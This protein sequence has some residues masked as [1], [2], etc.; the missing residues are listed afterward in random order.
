MFA[1]LFVLLY[2][3]HLLADYPLQTDHQAAHKGERTAVGWRANATHT[4][5]HVGTSAALLATG[6]V[7]LDLRYGVSVS[8]VALVWIGASHSFVDRGW[9]VERWMKNSL[10]EK[11]FEEGGAAP[12]DQVAHVFALMVAAL[13][14]AGMS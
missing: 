13:A 9:P 8:V 3:A 5:T 10:Q 2:V 4:L 6:A 11:S 12:I 1:S 7:V 14:I